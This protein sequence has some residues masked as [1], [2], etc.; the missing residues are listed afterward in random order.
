LRGNLNGV[1]RKKLERG[2]CRSQLEEGSNGIGVLRERKADW[3]E[4]R[5][6]EV[7]AGG[8]WMKLEGADRRKLEEDKVELGEDLDS[9]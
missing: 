5:E 1:K 6:L 3:T 4:G 8:G 2:G 7:L 9:R